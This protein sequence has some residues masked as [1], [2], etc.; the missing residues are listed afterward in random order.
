M[1]IS[2]FVLDEVDITVLESDPPAP[3]I[4]VASAISTLAVS[5]SLATSFC[6]S[7]TLAA[8]ISI[9]ACGSSTPSAFSTRFV[10]TLSPALPPKN[11]QE[12]H[13]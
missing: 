1:S 8:N 13:Q 3:V 6:N 5:K 9:Y 2:L 11:H 12:L 4:S 10:A 7:G